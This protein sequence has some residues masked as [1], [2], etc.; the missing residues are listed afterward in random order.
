MTFKPVTV[1]T[2][3]KAEKAGNGFCGMVEVPTTT[4]A[5]EGASDTRSFDNV[6]A[7]PPGMRGVLRGCTLIVSSQ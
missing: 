4:A 5:A 6:I 1:I 2:S 7:E 3:G